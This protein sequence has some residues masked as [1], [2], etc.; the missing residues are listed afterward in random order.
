MGRQLSIAAA[1]YDLANPGS[2][3]AWAERQEQWIAE[4]A[5]AGAQL[6]VFPEYGAMELAALSGR[7]GELNL[8]FEAVSD[9][10]AEANA[11][12]RRLAMKYGI[13]L[14][15]GSGPQRRAGKTF[16]V[17]HVFGPRGRV[18]RYDKLM[19]TPWER[20]TCAISGGGELMVFDIGTVRV[21][22]VICYDIEFPLIARALAE[23]GAEVILTP[24]NTETEWGYWRVRVGAMARA[25]ENQCYVV[26]VPVVGPSSYAA[27]T[28]NVGAAGVF[29]PSDQGFPAGGVVALGE[30]N[31]PQWLYAKLDLELLATVRR[32]GNVQT[33]RHWPEQPGAG[34]M[35]AARVIDIGGAE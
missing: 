20:D 30:M 13:T 18:A 34:A 35:P 32:A 24:S 26:Q 3:A 22:L 2:L 15:S 19:P 4:A 17:A 25:L 21:G 5:G 11:I 23:A 16:N 31:R 12:H 9:A 1:Q 29:A 8:S 7:G 27:V 14:V 10:W 33:Y 28:M 6:L